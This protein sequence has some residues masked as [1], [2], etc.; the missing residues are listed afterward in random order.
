VHW[1][2]LVLS[3]AITTIFTFLILVIPEWHRERKLKTIKPIEIY[4]CVVC[5]KTIEYEQKV[6]YVHKLLDVYYSF[7]SWKCLYQFTKQ[8][9]I[10]TT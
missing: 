4:V 2:I 8:K 5:G 10:E 3:I 6:I 7:C 9:I 1:F